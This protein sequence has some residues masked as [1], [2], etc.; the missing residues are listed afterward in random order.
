MPY[1]RLG[2]DLI[3]SSGACRSGVFQFHVDDLEQVVDRLHGGVGSDSEALANLGYFGLNFLGVC[4]NSLL[5]NVNE[6]FLILGESSLGSTTVQTH[7]LSSVPSGNNEVVGELYDLQLP[8]ILGGYRNPRCIGCEGNGLF[9]LNS[10]VVR[11]RRYF[12]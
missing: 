5:L 6:R 9:T 12:N 7:R 1:F 11:G 8:R 4:H 3:A 2:F 10:G